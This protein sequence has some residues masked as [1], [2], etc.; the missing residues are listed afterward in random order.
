MLGVAVAVAALVFRHAP[1]PARWLARRAQRCA[2]SSRRCETRAAM[3][4]PTSAGHV[5]TMC[6]P[7]ADHVPVM[8][9]PCA[10]HVLPPWCAGKRCP[11][12]QPHVRQSHTDIAPLFRNG[13]KKSNFG[14]CCSP[15]TQRCWV[16]NTSRLWN[17]RSLLPFHLR[18]I[19]QVQGIWWQRRLSSN[20]RRKPD[21]RRRHS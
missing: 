12:Q 16:Q 20:R 13:T 4:V 7:C 1:S 14:M 17:K 10:D 18:L 9:W 2:R 8:C 21:R 19:F 5:P 3:Y 15:S 11:G 6:R